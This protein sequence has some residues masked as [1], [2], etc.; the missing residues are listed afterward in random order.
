MADD[1]N[2]AA[3]ILANDVPQPV[4]ERPDSQR[5][6]D[7]NQKGNDAEIAVAVR[8]NVDVRICP[9]NEALQPLLPLAKRSD[10]MD[11]DEN[12]SAG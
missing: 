7:R 4:A 2:R 10:P 5:A 8:L 9:S 11:R 3:G 1:R 12:W 6:K